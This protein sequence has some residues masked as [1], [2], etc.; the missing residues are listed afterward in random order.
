[1]FLVIQSCVFLYVLGFLGC[2][3]KGFASFGIIALVAEK[4]VSIFTYLFF[5]IL[6]LRWFILWS[7][8]AFLS[9][10]FQKNKDILSLK[11]CV[12]FHFFCH[13][14]QL[15]VSFL[16]FL[17]N[18]GIFYSSLFLVFNRAMFLTKNKRATAVHSLKIK[19][20]WIS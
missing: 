8:S 7:F 19:K 9:H 16:S 6:D 5:W 3:R 11:T 1:M 4:S 12:F 2:P 17:L 13:Y 14:F 15:Y 10:K 18:L 20:N